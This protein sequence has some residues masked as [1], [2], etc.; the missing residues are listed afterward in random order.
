MAAPIPII[1]APTFQPGRLP[2]RN[3]ASP[4][5]SCGGSP[6]STNPSGTG[7][8]SPGAVLPGSPVTLT[9]DVTPGANP[10][11]TGL[12][13]TADLNPIGGPASQPFSGSGN[14]FTFNTT[15]AVGTT[16]G[17][18]SLNF[19]V[20]DSQSRS[21]SGSIS[22]TVNDPAVCEAAF[23]HTYQIQGTTETSPLAGQSNVTVQGV[24]VGDNEGPSPA[25]RGFFLQDETGDGNPA[26]SDGLFVFNFNNNNVSAGQ[27]VRITG[28]V[29]ENQG[30]TEITPN[31]G[32]IFDCARTTTV[33]PTD[34]T[35]PFASPDYLERFE[36]MLVRL[37]QTLYVTETFQLGRFDQLVM[38][39]GSR[40]RQPTQ[41]ADPGAPAQAIQ[42][43]NDLNRIIIDDNSQAQNPDPIIFGRGTAPLSA[44][45]TLREG[46]TATGIVGVLNYTWAGNA[47]SGNASRVP[48]Y[49]RP[50]FRGG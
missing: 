36:S 20:Q 50:E 39:S 38:S 3:T 41:M 27:V 1:T 40:L 18:K 26:T 44:D 4:L 49:H 12:S 5:N 30:Q 22:L 45:N 11:S 47:A 9:V 34:V 29:S 35:L 43:A 37:P 14:S 24:V 25:L 8:A 31:I 19:T 33:T 6:V 17:P 32:G 46:D 48:A 10:A 7:Q 13:V 21:S 2:P 42:T 16:P 23:T 15:V 28:T